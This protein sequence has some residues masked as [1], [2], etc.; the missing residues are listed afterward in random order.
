MGKEQIAIKKKK[1]N[2]WTPSFKKEK[3]NN[4]YRFRD[5]QECDAVC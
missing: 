5:F 1:K 2:D 3:K 4:L